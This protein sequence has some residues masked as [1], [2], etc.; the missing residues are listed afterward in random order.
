MRIICDN[1]DF[2]AADKPAG[3][4]SIPERSGP[5]VPCALTELEA[6]LGRKL[7]VIHRLDKAASGAI[8]FAKNA[9]AHRLICALFARRE[10]SKRYTV[11]VCGLPEPPSGKIN[12]PLRS[13]GSGRTAVDHARGKPSLTAYSTIR[14]FERCAL[15]D[16]R[17]I[18][19]RRHQ[20]RAHFYAIGHPVAGDLRYGDRAAQSAFPRL[21]LHSREIA[22]NFKGA[23]V[24]ITAPAPEEFELAAATF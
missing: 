11:L 6:Q 24:A 9:H 15:M 23:P 3:L 21:M 19:G 22:F 10:V 5:G 4:A 14:R 1:E 16:A 8:L 2:L 20:I 7:F 12:L 17:I 18:T 13:F